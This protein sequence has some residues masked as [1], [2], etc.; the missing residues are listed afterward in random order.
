[1]TPH[2]LKSIRNLG[3]SAHIDAG[4]TTLAE[5]ILFYTGRIHRMGEIRAKDGHG[6]TMDADPLE[7][8]KG[9][10]ISTAATR[11][12]WAGHTLHLVDTPGHVD[13]TVEVERAL[14]VLDGAILVLSAVHGVQA[15][16]RTVDAQMRR[17]GV[18]AIGFVNKCDLPGADVYRVAAEVEAVLGRTTA[19]V[20]LPLFDNHR[21]VGVADLVRLQRL[22]FEGAHGEQVVRGP[23][24]L[25]AEVLDARERLL[26]QLTLVDDALAARL[27]EGEVTVADIDAALARAVRADALTPLFVGSALANVGVQ[28]LLD[29]VV[30]W[31]PSPLDREVRDASD[32]VVDADPEGPLAAFVF[33]T[34]EGRFG[35]HAWVRVYRGTLR[36]GD[37]V[38]ADGERVRV[39]RLLALDPLGA[40]PI[41]EARAGDIC[42][43]FGIDVPSGTTL[44]DPLVPL[45]LVPMS[46]AEPMMRAAATLVSGDRDKL[47]KALAR[48]TR[49][50]PTLR[51][52]THPETGELLLEGVGELQLEVLVE[53]LAEAGLVLELS[54]P[55]VARRM[56]IR[57]R[58]DFDHFLRMQRGGRGQYAHVVGFVEPAESVE[59]VW[60]VTG[61]AIPSQFRKAVEQGFLQ[62]AERGVV[63]EIPLVG[64]R[65][66][67]TDG[68]AHAKDSSERDFERAAAFALREAVGEAD[69][70]VLEPWV[71]VETDA[72]AEHHGAVL[73]LLAQRGGQIEEAEVIDARSRVVAVVPLD[74]MF[75]FSGVLRSA[76]AGS[77]A[78]AMDFARFAPR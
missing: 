31:L 57:G 42:A 76:T 36:T 23:L 72:L 30:A 35:Q 40:V 55:Q 33:K 19:L 63:D 70:V 24:A 25:T 20:Q 37:L 43:V 14:R 74:A 17:Y 59:V 1:M 29:G 18:P 44:S 67:V 10:T 58:A 53:R 56:A 64:V 78:F 60:A 77:G 71:R 15:Q 2:V 5:R 47:G 45:T 62:A 34:E 11:A 7:K 48:A 16:T 3:I 39:G 38:V 13:F 75:G 54:A 6:A 51:V 50:D 4:K 12:E 61:G 73:G 32:D 66:T 68:A 8:K 65:I 22:S 52:S 46:V 9:I 27:L 28:P 69:A 41:D 26:D 49:E 21:L